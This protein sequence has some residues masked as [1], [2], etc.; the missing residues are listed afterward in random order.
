MQARNILIIFNLEKPGPTYNSAATNHKLP[1]QKDL[2]RT[3]QRY[4]GRTA[5]KVITTDTSVD[6]FITSFTTIHIGCRDLL[7]S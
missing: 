5:N 6:L 7:Q 1:K 4:V 3:E 2:S